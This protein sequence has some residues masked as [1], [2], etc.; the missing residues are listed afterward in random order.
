[1]TVNTELLR[2]NDTLASDLLRADHRKIETHLDSLLLALKHLSADKVNGIRQDFTAIQRLATVHFEQEERVFYPEV[3][4]SAPLI[5]VQMDEEHET[6]RE[7][8]R[9]LS[10]LLE[11]FPLSPVQRDLDELYRLGIE[12]HDAIQVHIVDEEDQLLKLADHLLSA[13]EQQR[14]AAGMLQITSGTNI[15]REP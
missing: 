4:P 2:M 1:M 12:F 3:R 10:E 15:F 6:V 13:S 9:Y 5:L 7:T 14:I 11:S 8:E